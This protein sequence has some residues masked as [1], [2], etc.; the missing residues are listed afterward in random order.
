MI[1]MTARHYTRLCLYLC[2]ADNIRLDRALA[3]VFTQHPRTAL[4]TLISQGAVYINHEECRKQSRLLRGDEEIAIDFSALPTVSDDCVAEDLPLAVVYEDDDIMVINKAAGMVTHPGHG[5][6]VGTLQSALLHHHAALAE[7][8]RAGIVHRLDKDTSGLLVVAKTAAA[9]CFLLA[10]FHRRHVRR[11]YL[12]LVHGVPEATGKINRPL[13]PKRGEP[14]R[15][16][17][18][19]RDGKEAITRFAV[20]RRWAGFALLRCW[21]ET[22]RT[23]QIRAHLEHIGYPIVGDPVYCRRRR[24]FSFDLRRQALHA[25]KLHLLHPNGD[26]REWTIPPPNDLRLALEKLDSEE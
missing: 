7:L 4:Q 15:M 25:E 11:E 18:N 6:R 14:Q 10:Q 9:R 19:A 23:H 20:L 1:L 2:N 3:S 16:T 12:A 5:N 8:P 26:A 17:V 22:G 13:S 24:N 21:L